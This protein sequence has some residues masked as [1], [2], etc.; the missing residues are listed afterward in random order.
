MKITPG[1]L[2]SFISPIT[3]EITIEGLQKLTT[4]YVWMGDRHNLALSSPILIDLKLELISLRGLLSTAQF[5]IQNA[6]KGLE[7]SQALNLVRNGMISVSNGIIIPT[8]LSTNKFWIGDINNFPIETDTLPSGGLPDL[9]LQ[10]IWIGDSSNRPIEI[11]FNIITGTGLTGGPIIGNGTISIS[12]T[13]VTSGTYAYATV[14][15]NP[16]GQIL[17]AIDNSSQISSILSDLANLA[18]IVSALSSAVNALSAS[19]AAIETGIAAIGGFAAIILLQAQVLGLYGAVAALSN[20]LDNVENSV[21]ILIM[22]VADLYTQVAAVNT[23][24]DNLRLNTILADADVSIYGFKLINVADPIN[25]QDAAT[26]HYVDDAI[27]GIP[28]SLTI[29]LGGAVSGT[30]PS[31][32]TINTTA[33]SNYIIQTSDINL[34]NAQVLG[35]LANGLL[36][37]AASTG[38]LSIATPGIDY[39]SPGNPTYLIEDYTTNVNPLLAYGNLGMGTHVF[40]SLTLFSSTNTANVGIGSDCL[41]SFTT[42]AG[43]TAEGRLSLFSLVTGSSNTVTGFGGA[44][45]VTSGSNNSFYGTLG[46]ASMT[47]GTGNSFFG[48]NTGQHDNLTDCCFFGRGARCSFDGLTNAIAI[49]ATATV[50]TSNS[51]V[52]GNNVNV[53]IGTTSPAYPLDVVGVSGISI[54]SNSNRIINVTDPI[55]PLD[56]VNLETLEGS[57]SDLD[58]TL[59]G[60]VIGGPAVANVLT[61]S[62]GPTCLLTNIPA[63]GN[64]DMGGYSLQN[65]AQSP[66][67]NLDAISA[68]FLWDLMHDTVEVTWT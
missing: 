14:N 60:F 8:N 35:S 22:Q 15:V 43:N 16:Q 48:Y 42:G 23:R 7:N 38:V 40:H 51:M 68:Q 52:L 29:T 1:Y 17:T 10:N 44:Y 2:D 63:G 39:Y 21:G 11:L 54:N 49:G 56:V 27:S 26:K 6:K 31:N 47:T 46:A 12:N 32:T 65:L 67:A 64:V 24:I 25:P 13:G 41:Y 9:T 3:G 33:F 53:G 66:I 45:L 19:V 20:R 36:K 62:R 37:N 50:A 18:S 4:N 5:I 59:A 30:G 61:T 34:P 28:G 57:I 55:N 58:I